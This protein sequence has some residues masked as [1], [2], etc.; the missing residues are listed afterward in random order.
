MKKK[1]RVIYD[2]ELDEKLDDLIRDT[3]KEIAVK[4]CAEGY[5]FGDGEGE[6]RFDWEDKV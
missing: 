1:I 4:W 6:I 5:S 2:G 3:M